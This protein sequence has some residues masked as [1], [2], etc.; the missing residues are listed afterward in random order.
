VQQVVA[1]KNKDLIQERCRIYNALPEG[2]EEPGGDRVDNI[3]LLT[4][5]AYGAHEL[6]MLL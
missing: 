5:N 1:H 6:I 3:I 2:E 4:G